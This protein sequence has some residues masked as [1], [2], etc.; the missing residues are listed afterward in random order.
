MR[1]D[2]QKSLQVFVIATLAIIQG[3]SIFPYEDKFGCNRP[4]NMGKCVSATEAYDE[5]TTGESKAPY[6]KPYSKQTDEERAAGEG[7]AQNTQASHGS[8]PSS[9]T[10]L[11]KRVNGAQYDAY[12]DANYKE[13]AELVD[14]PVTPMV[15]PVKTAELLFLPYSDQ[16]RVLKGERIVTVILE[17]PK[18]VLG[19]YLKKKQI[20][21]AT[22]FE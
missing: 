12:L 4:N 18:F 6:A 7:D 3:C 16:S 5:M 11:P 15:K 10:S 2:F 14:A 19:D 20:I 17:E 22:P 8:A 1:K 13:V 21:M 9:A